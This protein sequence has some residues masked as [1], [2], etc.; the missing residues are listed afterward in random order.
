[1]CLLAIRTSAARHEVVDLHFFF[2]SFFCP[3]KEKTNSNSKGRVK[4]MPPCREGDNEAELMYTSRRMCCDPVKNLS[5]YV[6]LTTLTVVECQ[7]YR[8]INISCVSSSPR[9]NGI[10]HRDLKLEN[11][12][13]DGNGNV[14]VRTGIPMHWT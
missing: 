3:P 8:Q 1:M 11:I 12:L 6:T 10:V 4:G 5:L 14:K 2:P 9:Q 7:N 13:L